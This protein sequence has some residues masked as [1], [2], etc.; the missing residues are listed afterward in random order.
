MQVKKK[1]KTEV[2]TELICDFCGK[3]A[4]KD[5]DVFEFQEFHRVDFTA[6]YGSVFGDGNNVECDI[7]Q[8]CLH[9]LIAKHSRIVQASLAGG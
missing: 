3:V 6:G 5:K 8:Y 1:V 4:H 9:A 7:C 2:V